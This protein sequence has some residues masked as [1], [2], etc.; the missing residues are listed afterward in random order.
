MWLVR[1]RRWYV[2]IIKNHLIFINPNVY[3][4]ITHYLKNKKFQIGVKNDYVDR[5]NRP[6]DLVGDDYSKYYKW[7]NS[8]RVPDD[9]PD[10]KEE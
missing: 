4:L 6:V 1:K 7:G 8:W 9:S 3:N 2:F 5:Q 10:A